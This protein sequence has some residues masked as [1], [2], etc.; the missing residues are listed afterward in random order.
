[1]GDGVTGK[2][3]ELADIVRVV[4]DLEAAQKVA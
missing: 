4:D 2:L 1:M 3:C